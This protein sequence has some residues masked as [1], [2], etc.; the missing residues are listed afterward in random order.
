MAKTYSRSEVELLL[1]S[2]ER[3]ATAVIKTAAVASAEARPDKFRSFQAFRK[4]CDDFDTL[5]TLIEH[6]L[7]NMTAGHEKDLQQKFEELTLF[8]L[9]ATMTASLH[10]L[11]VLA[12]QDALPLGSR[13]MFAREL[14]HLH[15]AQEKM[16]Q[17]QYVSRIGDR[18]K[19]DIKAA[20]EI[21]IEIIDRSSTLLD[22]NRNRDAADT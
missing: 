5:S 6:R 10:F 3:S 8:L 21:L 12:E 20:E 2:L 18:T 11:R 14:R 19:A 1:G 4:S 13:D 7:K 17:P 15:S 22:F 16:D 9:G